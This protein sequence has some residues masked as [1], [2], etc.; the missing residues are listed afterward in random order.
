M[1]D[2]DRRHFLTFAGLGALTIGAMALTGC[3]PG[4]SGGGAAQA[5]NIR[6]AWWGGAERQK[7]YISSLKTFS[8]SF[9]DITVEPEFGDYDA[10][11]ER[12]TTQ[13]A[14]RDVPEVF[15]VPSPQVLTYRDA[16]IYRKL[17]DIDVLDLSAFSKEEL[18]LFK[19]DGE[20]NTLPKSMFSPVLRYNTTFMGED[21]ITLPDKLTWE[22]LSELLIDYSKNNAHGRKGTSYGAYHDMPFESFLRQ[23]GEDLWTKDGKL[24]ASVDAVAEWINWWENLRNAG[25]TTTISEQN[26]IQPGWSDTGSKVLVSFANSNHIVDEAPAFPDYEFDQRDLP[27]FADAEA[28]YH[29]TYYSRFAMYSGIDDSAIGAAGELMNFNLNSLDLLKLVGLSA[30]APP[31]TKL[32]DSYESSATETEQKVIAV[33]RDIAKREQRPRSEAPAGSGTWRDALVR[34]LEGVTLGSVSVSDAAKNFVKAVNAEIE[35]A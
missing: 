33:T 14:A 25:A 23:R 20:L 5:A 13:M 9:P 7:A 31:S 35:K 10:Y 1:Q 26:G 6:F 22:S 19:L 16:G 18:E 8:K 32:L 12:M 15:W 4:G 17:D 34:E 27:A 29:F 28:G 3:A 21:G 2:L 24:G 30:G 11:Q